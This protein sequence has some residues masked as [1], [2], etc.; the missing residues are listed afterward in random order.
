VKRRIVTGVTA[1]VLAAG[2]VLTGAPAVA[3]D[4][5]DCCQ[6]PCVEMLLKE[7]YQMQQTFR[8][9][10]AKRNL[11]QADYEKAY[12]QTSDGIAAEQAAQPDLAACK[13]NL[14]APEPLNQRK[15]MTL[16][17]VLNAGPPT[18]YKFSVE[19]K[20]EACR[21]REDQ[22]NEYSKLAPCSEL[23]DATLQHE[24]KHLEQC[25]A[26]KH[27]DVNSPNQRAK[28]E[29]DAYET[30]IGVLKKTVQKL[31]DICAKKGSCRDDRN[32]ETAVKL[33]KELDQLEK[34]LGRR[35]TP[36]RPARRPGRK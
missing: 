25:S 35:K 21:L 26:P 1:A 31:A 3:A 34:T 15:W 36:A 17:W 30:E 19:T 24:K 11:S 7:A 29:V 8:Q 20:M 2:A 33:K 27:G 16:G 10:A 13:W 14:P 23:A 32:D 5:N 4:C 28:W 9:L 12:K 6:L 18:V 22:M